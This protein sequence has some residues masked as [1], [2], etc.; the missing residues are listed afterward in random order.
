MATLEY[1]MI[2][3]NLSN[4][5]VRVFCRDVGLE[6]PPPEKIYFDRQEKEIREA[7]VEDDIKF[8]FYRES[9]SQLS[10]DEANH[11]NLIRGASYNYLMRVVE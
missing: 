4:G 9:F 3:L 2:Q 5:S 6:W 11:P 1:D 8:I 10:D 7:T